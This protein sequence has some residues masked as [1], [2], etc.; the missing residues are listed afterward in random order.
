MRKKRTGNTSWSRRE[1]VSVMTSVPLLPAALHRMK[2]V[3]DTPVFP[4]KPAFEIQGI[5]LNAA[6]THPMSKGSFEEIKLFLNNRL[7]NQ[8]VPPHYDAFDRSTALE[9]FAKLINASP[10]EIAWVPSTMFAENMIVRGLSIPGSGAQVVTDAFHFEGS[11]FMYD[12]LSKEE[13]VRVSVVKP[14]NNKIDW[15][16]IDAALR[17]GTRLLAISL[18]SAYN[19]FQH[20]LKMICDLAHAKGVLVYADIIQAA[21]AVPI[22][23]RASGVDF[24]AC[25]TYKWLMGDFGIGFLYVRADRLPLLKRN[26]YGYRQI[27]HFESHLLP[28]DTPGNTP[29]EST[30]KQGM[31]GHFEVGTFASEG[32]AALR[33]S[34]AYLNQLGIP[35]IQQYRQPMIKRLQDK[36]DKDLYKPLT[37]EDSVSPIVGFACSEAT[38][39]G[40]RQKIEK[41]GI[42]IQVY[43]NR[44]RV[45]P[46][47]YNDLEEIDRF[48]AVANRR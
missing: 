25:A 18:V 30:S 40:L 13:S 36:L 48:I 29:I 11:L 26:F 9:A 39:R 46:S 41:E 32:I 19:G 20:D 4:A 35:A 17:P 42:N 28:T 7:Q 43:Q 12:Q 33:Y 45:S 2:P 24:C 23:V 3:D 47:F 16:D 34:L 15:R 37:P 44:I 8:R 5:Y 6:Y 10:A 31:S 22:D 1:F 14:A 27:E 38:A 21:G